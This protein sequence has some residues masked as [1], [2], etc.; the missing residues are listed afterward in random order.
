MYTDNCH[1]P[2]L[3]KEVLEFLQPDVQNPLYLDVTFGGGGHTKALLDA[4]PTLKIIAFDWDKEAIKQ[5]QPLVEKYEGRLKLIWG[6][7]GHLYKLLKNNGI[8]Q[9]D[10]ILAD[11]GTSQNQIKEGD[12]FSIYN[13]TPLDMRMSNSHF[14]ATAA[15]IINYGQPEELREIFWR[16]GE[17]RHAKKIVEAIIEARQKKYI[18]TTFELA[19]IVECVVK[20]TES[21][22]IHPATKVFQALRIFVNHELDNIISFL[23]VALQT[24]KSGGKFACISFHSLEDRLVKQ[25]FQDHVRNGTCELVF[26]GA[27]APTES[28]I[29]VNRA[30]RSAKLRII[31]KN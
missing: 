5:G 14:K 23:P 8:G 7:F 26:K 3:L 16:Y 1:I 9:V 6:S 27:K 21:S 25:F 10:G 19:H 30:S 20:R 28:E 17:E 31:K 13:D 18:N 22:K 12:G 2:V 15:H 24:L 29:A 11:F 4:Y